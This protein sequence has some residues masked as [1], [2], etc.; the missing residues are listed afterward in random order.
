MKKILNMLFGRTSRYEKRRQSREKQHREELDQDDDDDDDDQTFDYLHEISVAAVSLVSIEEIEEEQ[1]EIKR[2]TAVSE[3][4]GLP[5][6]ALYELRRLYSAHNDGALK[7]ASRR[8][9]QFIHRR[10]AMAVVA[11]PSDTI[12]AIPSM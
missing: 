1:R 5:V 7:S 3:M 9:D 2:L 10:R 11:R 8:R 12:V 4:N 6:A